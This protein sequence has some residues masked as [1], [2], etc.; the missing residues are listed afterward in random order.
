[1]PLIELKNISQYICRDVNLKIR[2][3]ELMVLLGPNGAGKTTIANIIAGLTDYKGSVLFDGAAV[4]KLPANKREVGYL[5]QDLVLFPHLDVAANIAYGLTAK[6]QSPAQVASRVKQLLQ[7]MKIEHLASRYPKH[8]SGGEK[9][10]VALARALAPSPRVLLLDE[11]LSSLDLPTAKYLRTELKQLQRRLGITTA[12][13]THDLQEAE[14]MADRIA[15]LQNGG[16][17]QVDK[18]EKV[19]FYPKNER[20]SDFI[21]TPNILDCDYC[22][23]LGKGV[24]EVGCGGLPIIV[25]HDGESVH[26]IAF[27]PTDIRIEETHPP[28][29]EVNRFKALITSIKPTDETVRISLKVGKLNLLAGMPHHIFEDMSL[30]AG[31]EVF[32]IL[33][34]RRIKVYEDKDSQRSDSN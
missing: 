34:L 17:E 33:K 12:Y 28:G 22:R 23:S 18:P 25:P 1:M 29:P 9:Q 14:E 13:V 19:F 7:M 16:L 32:L 20:V 15:V 10:R 5:F 21:G 2:N 30:A 27:L 3:K 4:D 8:L 6:K 11:P 31:K 24:M 26:R